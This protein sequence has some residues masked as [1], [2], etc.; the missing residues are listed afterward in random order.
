[1][2]IEVIMAAYNNV[3][4]MKLVLEGY[5]TQIDSDFSICIADDGSR[6]AVAS[7]VTV[8]KELGLNI[9]HI[10]QED[11]GFRRGEILNKAIASSVAEYI[12][13]T[14]NDC[15]P[16]KFFISDYRESFTPETFILGRRIDLNELVSNKIRKN[17]IS[18]SVLDS[19]IWLLLNFVVGNLK[20]PARGMRLPLF[21]CKLWS[22]K[23]GGALGANMGVEKY[24]FNMT[25]LNNC[26]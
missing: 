3:R 4:D 13:L 17:K 18:I 23:G 11:K 24:V 19:T 8:Y 26:L 10:W 5:R 9:R 22:K 21:V 15:I 1:M 6:P 12:I 2:K 20:R 16:S 14:D 7:L 25:K